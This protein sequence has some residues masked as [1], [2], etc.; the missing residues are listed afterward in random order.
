VFTTTI[1]N[2]IV[3]DVHGPSLFNFHPKKFIHHHLIS[4]V[5]SNAS[6]NAKRIFLNDG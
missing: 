1:I 4:F 3:D 5:K 6:A 2:L